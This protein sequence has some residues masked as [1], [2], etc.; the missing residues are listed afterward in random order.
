MSTFHDQAA[1]QLPHC[2]QATPGN[3][4]TATRQ[5]LHA[6][7]ARTTTALPAGT[8]GPFQGP[9]NFT[10]W[11][12]YQNNG[13]PHIGDPNVIWT[14]QTARKQQY[15]ECAASSFHTQPLS[16]DTEGSHRVPRG[17][18]VGR[19]AT[20]GSPLNPHCNH[21]GPASISS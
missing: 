13:K 20:P 6:T 10:G 12:V 17:P 2:A 1:S 7:N 11:I 3:R 4:R 14:A 8:N 9:T 5:L 18:T 19:G 15:P 21:G 16:P